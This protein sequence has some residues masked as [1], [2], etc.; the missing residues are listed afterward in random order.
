METS[1]EDKTSRFYIST[2]VSFLVSIFVIILVVTYGIICIVTQE[3]IFH[4]YNLTNI[5]YKHGNEYSSLGEI[6]KGTSM[7][8][9]KDNKN[10]SAVEECDKKL[11][12]I[13]LNSSSNL[14]SILRYTSCD[15]SFNSNNKLDNDRHYAS[16]T[17]NFEIIGKIFFPIKF[18]E[19]DKTVSIVRTL[20]LDETQFPLMNTIQEITN[21]NNS[22]DYHKGDI[23]E[24]SADGS[25]SKE[26]KLKGVIDHIYDNSIEVNFEDASIDYKNLKFDVTSLKRIET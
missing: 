21:I 18:L 3:V 26:Y 6:L 24:I 13:Y 15:L 14:Q 19:G 16:I 9:G 8:P 7:S 4:H 10:E 17:I 5:S 23:I 20:E 2:V 12:D 25:N 11:K 22:S 1:V